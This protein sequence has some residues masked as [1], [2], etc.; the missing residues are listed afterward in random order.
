MFPHSFMTWVGLSLIFLAVG[1]AFGNLVLLTGSVFLLLAMLIIT[2]LQPPSGVTIERRTPRAICW[3]GDTVTVDRRMTATRG[4]GPIFIH[5]A[6][7][8]ELEVEQGNNLRIVWKWAGTKS[9]DLSYQVRFPK[10]GEFTLP[11]ST[12]ESQAPLGVR[13]GQ[14]TSSGEVISMSVV[15]R[16]RGITRLNEIRVT[17]KQ[18]RY[19]DDLAQT[20]ISNSE[21]RIPRTAVLRSG[22][23]HQA[24]Q[25]EGQFEGGA[26]RQSTAGERA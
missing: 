21:F 3:S 12:W 1:L 9:C 23:P 25:L 22:R 11:A 13:R 16:I 5:D 4:M 10:R 24:H 2:A 17:T 14:S 19:Q 26:Q 20:G 8:P 15:P 6:L 18:T 7:P